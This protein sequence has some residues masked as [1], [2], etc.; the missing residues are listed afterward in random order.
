MNQVP[1]TN[2]S[3]GCT[4]CDRSCMAKPVQT[5]QRRKTTREKGLQHLAKIKALLAGEPA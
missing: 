3:C 2:P 1:K 4:N 5:F